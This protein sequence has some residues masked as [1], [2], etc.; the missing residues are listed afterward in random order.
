MAKVKKS[1]EKVIIMGAGPAGLGAAFQLSKNGIEAM[2]VEKDDVVGGI[3]RTLKYKGYYFDEGGHAFFSKSDEVNKIWHALLGPSLVKVERLSRIYYQGKFFDFPLKPGNA[4]FG[5]GFMGSMVILG[6]YVKSRIFP[7]K[8]EKT[9]EQ[10][11]SN[12]F[13]KKL[14]QVFFKTYTE[15][16]WGIPCSQIGA[17]WARQRI[18]GVSLFSAIRHAFLGRTKSRTDILTG[19]LRYPPLG[20]GMMYEAM[21]TKIQGMGGSVVLDSEVISINHNQSEVLSIAVANKAGREKNFGGTKFISTIPISLLVQRMTPKPPPDVLEASRKL[22][23]RGLLVVHLIIDRQDLFPDNWLFIHSPEVKVARIQNYKNWSPRMV[24]DPTKTSLG[25]EYFCNENDD[26]WNQP[27]ERL[28]AIAIEEL[29]KLSIVDEHAILD[30]LVFKIP[31]AYPVYYRG[32]RE[33]L[34]TVKRYLATFGNLQT[35]GR[36]GMYQYS[37][38]YHSILTGLMAARNILGSNFNIWQLNVNEDYHDV[39]SE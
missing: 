32:Y 13:G 17:E 21:K 8:K 37:H 2:V 5:M 3:S 18:G 35:V 28:I 15:K 9:F 14:Y 33:P 30:A 11:V 24:P 7:Y 22:R 36:G 39:K 27:E 31:H 20:P 16:V 19:E 34:E 26:F 25:L 29:K 12:R 4:L 6:S 1:R 38:M 10:W 23:Y